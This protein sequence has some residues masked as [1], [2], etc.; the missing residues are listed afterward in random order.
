[1]VGRCD[2]AGRQLEEVVGDVGQQQE[3]GS[4]CPSVILLRLALIVRTLSSIKG[5]DLYY[6]S[7]QQHVTPI[8]LG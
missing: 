6:E 2:L 8:L 7:R 5:S 1:M 4:S 3:E